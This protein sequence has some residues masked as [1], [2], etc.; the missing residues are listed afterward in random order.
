M[1]GFTRLGDASNAPSAFVKELLRLNAE[2]VNAK[3]AGDLE[4]VSELADEAALLMRYNAAGR[5]DE[6]FA[7]KAARQA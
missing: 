4:R 3:R 7:S 5:L 2:Q 6:Y 1:S